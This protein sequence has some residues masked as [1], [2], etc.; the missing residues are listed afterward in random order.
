MEGSLVDQ[1][2][3][4]ARLQRIQRLSEEPPSPAHAYRHLDHIHALVE[5]C[6]RELGVTSESP[7][8]TEKR[9]LEN[10]H[11]NPDHVHLHKPA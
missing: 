6:L 4:I 8:I 7:S 11:S 9:A 5:I 1:D 2:A 3:L 10:H